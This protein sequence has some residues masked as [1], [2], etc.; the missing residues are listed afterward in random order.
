MERLQSNVEEN[1]AK[2]KRKVSKNQSIIGD[3]L[4]SILGF[5]PKVQLL[6]L[7]YLNQLQEK[8]EL[9]NRFRGDLFGEKTCCELSK[10]SLSETANQLSAKSHQKKS[11]FQALRD[12]CQSTNTS[13]D[14]GRKRL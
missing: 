10:P 6:I 12:I 14:W 3:A 1:L 7:F 13:A 5:R 4:I 8:K 2:T 9:M 11:I